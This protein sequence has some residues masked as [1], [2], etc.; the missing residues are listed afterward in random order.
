MPH[1]TSWVH[2]IAVPV[3]SAMI[4]SIPLACAAFG[5]DIAVVVTS[6]PVH[7]LTAAVMAGVAVP[8]LLVEGQASPHTFALKPSGAAAVQAANIFVRVS[9]AIEPFTTRVIASLPR[10]VTVVTLADAP[11]LILLN[12]RSGATFEADGHAHG[13]AGHDAAHDTAA[14]HDDDTNGS[15][16]GHVWLDPANAAA[17]VSQLAAVLAQKDPE[18]SVQYV[19]NAAAVKARLAALTADIEAQVKPVQGR[20]FVVFH[21][22]YQYFETRFGLPASGAI[23]VSADVTPSA[24]RLSAVRA[25]IATLDAACVFAEPLFSP[26]L[27]A[28]VT[29]GTRAR[30]GTLDP[31]GIVL[32]PGPE[33][34]FTLMRSLATNLTACLKPAA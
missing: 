9:D 3:I 2:N 28:A 26:K 19:A 23:T 24:K 11:G 1:V 32:E 20:P 15:R 16:D 8:S 34:Y 21:D 13:H 30:A 4:T 7:S 31:E 27:V 5:A 18:H 14:D 22:A 6:K 12:K 17:M 33:L 10:S 29:E 25:K